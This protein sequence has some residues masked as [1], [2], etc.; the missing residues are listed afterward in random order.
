MTSYANDFALLA[1]DPSIVE[2]ESR[3]NWLCSLLVRWVDGKQLAIAPQKSSVTLFTFDTH[4][5]RLHPQVQIGDTV[6]PLNR[7]PKILGVTLDT[8]FTFGPHTRDCVL[9]TSRELNVI[10]ALAGSS[11]DFTTEALVATY[12]AIVRPILN[13]AASIWFTQVSST[14]LDKLEVHDPKQG[15]ENRDRI[16]PKGSGVPS[17]GGDWGAPSEGT[18]RTA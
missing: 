11:W 3:A 18:L 1:S 5:S 14:H 15:P 10:K 17:Q 13:Y 7:T 8:H 6:A 2:A 9:R 16:P 4:Q 12:K